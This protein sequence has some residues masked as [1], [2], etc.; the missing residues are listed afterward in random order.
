VQV[1]RSSGPGASGVGDEEAP[2]ILC[3]TPREIGTRQSTVP[4]SPDEFETFQHPRDGG[5]SRNHDEGC[6]PF[7]EGVSGHPMEPGETP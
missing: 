6:H 4:E 5:V 2:P 7:C 1:V 3:D